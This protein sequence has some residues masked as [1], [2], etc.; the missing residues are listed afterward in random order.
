MTESVNVNSSPSGKDLKP[1][2][3]PDYEARARESYGEALPEWVAELAK[4]ANR[5]TAA[6]AG[7]KVGI[8]ASTVTQ[9][10]N[11]SYGAKDWSAIET[12]VRGV[13]M[14]ETVTCPILDEISKDHCLDEQN[15]PF[16]GTSA[17]RTALYNECR[18][19]RCPHSRLKVEASADV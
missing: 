11:G 2:E 6:A 16:T 5:T 9:L 12:R 4:L 14:K 7:R 1:G 17:V 15:K 3:K 19:G 8:G 13:L 18:S 10:I